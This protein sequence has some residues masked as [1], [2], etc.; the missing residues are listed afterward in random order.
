VYTGWLD[1][2]I[3][4][5]SFVVGRL[6]SKTHINSCQFL[7]WPVGRPGIKADPTKVRPE[8]IP[9]RPNCVSF[10]DLDQLF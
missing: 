10:F 2:L 5:V 3:E 9:V 6:A 7:C 4:M 8:R 1:L